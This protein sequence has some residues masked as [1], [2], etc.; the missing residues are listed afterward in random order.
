MTLRTDAELVA[1]WQ[2][3]D[4]QA[5]DALVER[6]SRRVHGICLRYFRDPADA[7]EAAQDTF[8]TLYRRGHTFRGDA[9]LSTWLFRVA[10]NACHDV[11]RRRGR[12]PEELPLTPARLAEADAEVPDVAAQVDAAELDPEL[13][14]ALDALDPEQR[15]AVVLRDVVGL[16]YEEVAAR[17]GIAVGTAKSRV[18]R[19]HARLAATLSAPAPA[20]ATREPAGPRARRTSRDDDG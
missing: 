11:A 16:S 12:R 17:C 15:D 20:P 6:F 19:A 8:V 10:T 2:A 3:G 4:D 18:H 5:F 1:A 14:S 9:K 7:E 13:R